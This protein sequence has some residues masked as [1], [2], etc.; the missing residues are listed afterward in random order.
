MA[1]RLGDPH[2]PGYGRIWHLP[3]SFTID[4]DGKL[5]DNGWKDKQPAWTQE[6]LHQIVPL[7]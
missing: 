5:V 1:T 6:R 7:C 3:V 2:V 4:R